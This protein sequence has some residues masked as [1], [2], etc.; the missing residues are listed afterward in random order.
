MK[1]YIFCTTTAYY[2]FTFNS[3]IPNYKTGLKLLLAL[4]LHLL[5]IHALNYYVR[6]FY[7]MSDK[8]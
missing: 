6:Y 2:S 5:V 3:F 8:L 1:L 7:Q 4:L